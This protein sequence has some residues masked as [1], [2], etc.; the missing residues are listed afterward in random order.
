MAFP[1]GWRKRAAITIAASQVSGTG[2]LTDFPV[3]LDGTIL[4]DTGI[5]SAVTIQDLTWGRIGPLLAI[6]LY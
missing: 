2:S 6:Y 3:F 4:D 1:V 5:F